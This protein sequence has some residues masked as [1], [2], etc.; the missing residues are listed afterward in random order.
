MEQFHNLKKAFRKKKGGGKKKKAINLSLQ[1]D[2]RMYIETD[3]V[4]LP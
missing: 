1:Q 3:I 2:C 4:L